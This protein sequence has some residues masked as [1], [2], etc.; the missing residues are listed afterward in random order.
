MV[1]PSASQDLLSL[2]ASVRDLV[3]RVPES[4]IRGS[5]RRRETSEARRSGGGGGRARAA[6]LDAL[7][8]DAQVAIANL[9]L[10]TQAV[11][12]CLW[13]AE[14]RDREINVP[15]LAFAVRPGLEAA[16]EIAW[17]LDSSIDSATRA[18]R[19]LTWRFA[20]LRDMRLLLDELSETN[21]E[22]EAASAEVDE[23]ERDLLDRV[24]A[25][26]WQADA[27]VI[28]P[29]GTTPAALLS[30]SG[31]RERIPKKV[32]LARLVAGR[33]SA[34]ALLSVPT[35]AVRYGMFQ[36]MEVEEES[37][38]TGQRI[39]RIGGFLLDSNLLI[40]LAIIAVANSGMRLASWNG[41]DVAAVHFVSE[42]LLRRAGV[43][44]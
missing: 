34:Y 13:A 40:G 1:V 23:I 43:R 15:G 37:N 17:L 38:T 31:A 27:T 42:E 9:S 41:L 25:A 16:G 5:S 2:A 39:A 14:N 3:S 11:A 29:G 30:T 19:Y 28:G 24:A 26:N 36:G 10:T 20:D 22:R 18:R 12:D 44:I 35:H 6:L 7:N 8:V 33:R 21:E 4:A 32:E